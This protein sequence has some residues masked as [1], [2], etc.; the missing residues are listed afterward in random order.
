MKKN[1]I[2]GLGTLF[3]FSLL[4][5]C[6]GNSKKE[7]EQDSV[8]V[9]AEQLT[10]PTVEGNFD[11]EPEKPVDG[12]LKAVVELGA[13]GFN[14]FIINVDKQ[15]RW[16]LVKPRFGSSS[17]V[18]EGATVEDTRAKLKEYIQMLL[19]DH[20]PGNNIYFVV[21]S[22]A[23]KEPIIEQI[24][25]VLRSEKYYVNVVTPEEEATYAYYATVPKAYRDKAYVVDMGSGNT[26]LAY[27]ENGKVVTHETY[28]A[29]YAKKG[30]D[31]ETVYNEVGA[32]AEKI[33]TALSEYCFII[34]GV[35]YQLGQF[36]NGGNTDKQYILLSK[37]AGDYAS[38]AAK[39]GEK[40]ECGLNIYA[41]L[42]EKS[43]T[44]TVVYD[45]KSN[46]T[47]GFLLNMK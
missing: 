47:I 35:P 34:G 16:E 5:A 1:V 19:D 14:S 2:K 38:F 44:Q 12:S 37:N 40:V 9:N 25:Q 26:K 7:S 18:E 27:M 45:S 15:Q 23:A 29:K 42:M 46:F 30:F 39:E 20:V 31:N 41:A 6:G 17:V 43:K 28:G 8:Q 32:I 33:P 3:L 11:F 4:V 24:S 36:T 10:P 22:G 13:S 21:S